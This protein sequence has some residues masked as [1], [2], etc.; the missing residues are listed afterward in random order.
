VT[1][2][3]PS[4][5]TSP[6]WRSTL[7]GQES[8]RAT[9][10]AF[11]KTLRGR[12]NQTH[13]VA[14]GLDYI[15]VGP[16]LAYL[17]HI[18]GVGSLK[19]LCASASGA[20]PGA[21]KHHPRRRDSGARLPTAAAKRTGGHAHCLRNDLPQLP[22]APLYSGCRREYNGPSGVAASSVVLANADT[23]ML[24]KRLTR[25]EALRASIVTAADKASRNITGNI[26]END[27]ARQDLLTQAEKLTLPLGWSPVKDDPYR[28]D[29]VPND[30]LGWVLKCVGL[31]MS[32]LA[33]SLGAPF[34]FDTLSKFVNLRGA[35]TPPGE[36]KKSA[37]QP[38]TT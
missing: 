22:P 24:V 27:K 21:P 20:P 18:D 34:W 37:P 32:V 14:A 36:T 29:Q 33:A 13:S 16:T 11:C 35:G 10:P 15:G 2:D 30:F 6:G 3:S 19:H 9:K 31:L 8:P 7:A 5:S 12:C 4:A 28:T 23:I 26:A 1:W 38:T 25:D 17:Y